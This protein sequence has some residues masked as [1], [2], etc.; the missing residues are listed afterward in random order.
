VLT[1]GK[2]RER[3]SYY[4]LFCQSRTTTLGRVYQ[5]RRTWKVNNN[6]AQPRMLMIGPT[7]AVIPLKIQAVETT[8]NAV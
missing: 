1:D 5:A 6:A 4:D 3:K 8:A 7:K 2:A